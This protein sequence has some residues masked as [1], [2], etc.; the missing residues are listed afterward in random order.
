M[1]DSYGEMLNEIVGRAAKFM[2]LSD[3]LRIH[4]MP[5]GHYYNVINPNRTT[6]S[7]NPFYAPIEWMISLTREFHDYDMIKNVS[8]D[9]RGIFLSLDELNIVDSG[10]GEVKDVYRQTMKAVKEFG[11]LMSAIEKA[12][13]KVIPDSEKETIAKEG[14]EAMGEIY[15]LMLSIGK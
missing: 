12:S 15:K 6:S 8:R 11:E 4:N 13:D 3:I 10:S 9:C 5:K 2:K 7:G 1:A 14:Y